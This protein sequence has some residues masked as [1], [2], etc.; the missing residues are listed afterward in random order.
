MSKE[1]LKFLGKAL[2]ERGLISDTE[3]SL[4]LDYQQKHGVTLS[5]ALMEMGYVSEEDILTVIGKKIGM[6]FIADLPQ[7]NIPISVIEKVPPSLVQIYNIMPIEFSGKELTIVTSDPGNIAILDDLHFR[8]GCDIK[9]YLAPEKDVV[10]TIKK[11]YGDKGGSFNDLVGEIAEEHLPNVDDKNADETSLKE[12]ASQA[13]VVKLLN[14]ILVQAIKDRAS[15]IHLEPF[16]DDFKVRYR[17]DGALYEMKSPP[18]SLALALTSRVKVMANLDISERRLPQDGRI[19]MKVGDTEVDLRVSTLPTVFGESVVMRVLDQSVVSLSLD[20]VGMPQDILT[21]FRRIIKKPNGI[22]L[23]TGP[24]GSGKTTTLYS[25]LKEINKVEYKIITTEDPVEYDIE[26]IIQVP[27]IPKIGLSFAKCLRSILRQDPDI[28][29]VGEIRDEETAQIAIQASLTGHLVF[30]TLHTNDAPG[31]VTR[32][33]DMGVEPFL[34]TSSL[35]AVIAQRLVRLVCS[36]CKEEYVPDKGLLED[37]GLTVEGVAGKTFYRARGCEF[38]NRT[39]YKGRSGI[40]EFLEI[41]DGLKELILTKPSASFLRQKA[42]ENG[43]RT[44]RED[45]LRKVFLGETTLE[46]VVKETQLYG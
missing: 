10:E 46:E 6:G 39:G 33:I 14:L 40:F 5:R 13:P 35:E 20:Q 42:Q 3:L 29:M 27:V 34:I 1:K 32:L 12:L 43:M 18:K 41:D 22:V 9:A 7:R 23:V 26:G 15:D 38:C 11:Y 16:E 19:L 36:K 37:V 25:A 45:G 28:I 8:L 31:A 2:V 24:T 44:L 17:V 30:S 4:A 21:K